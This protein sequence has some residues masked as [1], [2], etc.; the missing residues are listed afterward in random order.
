[1]ALL[2][3]A[4]VALGPR[5]GLYV[6]PPSPDSYARRAVAQMSV[7]LYADP[8]R[9]HEVEA[10]VAARAHGADSYAAT[11]PVLADALQRLGGEH[12]RFYP[13][14]EARRAF[15]PSNSGSAAVVPSV[16]AAEDGV[17]VLELPTLLSNDEAV[18]TGYVAAVAAG[19]REHPARCG[20][21]V[22]VRGNHG[23]DLWPMLAALDPLLTEGPVL[24]FVHRD[25]TQTVS[26]AGAD[27]LLDGSVQQSVA[28]PPARVA[29]PV[30]L[31]QDEMT[32]SSAEAV[33][34]SFRGQAMTR[35]FGAP[36]H[37][38]STANQP[39]SLY[40]GAVANLTVA[41]DADRTGA[42][43]DGPIPPDSPTARPMT[44]ARSWLRRTC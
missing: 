1:M 24:S 26:V 39:L 6:W 34:L 23:G 22:D 43:W 14:A 44:A 18:T 12:S 41:V 5:F 20:Y 37:G 19:L 35:S 29:A 31:L 11:Y 3:T 17:V 7:G 36:T 8:H 27:V 30:A 21:V 16:S 32:G 28:D 40:D 13:P 9:L 33:V 2:L 10:E 42:Q 38:F 4:A 25:T 15:A